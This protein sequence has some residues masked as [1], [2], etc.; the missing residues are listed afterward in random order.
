MTSGLAATASAAVAA[1]VAP[2]STN[3]VLL[4]AVR[5]QTVVRWPRST[6]V[7]AIAD[8]ISPSP[9]TVTWLVAAVGF[10]VVVMMTPFVSKRGVRSVV[11]P[12]SVTGWPGWC[13]G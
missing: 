12:R 13:G 8:P 9:S 4:L 6:K 7:L 3:G 1:A 2:L 5:F 11:R 10:L